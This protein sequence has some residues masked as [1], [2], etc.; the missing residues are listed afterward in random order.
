MSCITVLACSASILLYSLCTVSSLVLRGGPPLFSHLS[1]MTLS[2]RV[3]PLLVIKW[4]Y[5][6]RQTQGTLIP[7]RLGTM[8]PEQKPGG[9]DSSPRGTLETGVSSLLPGIS[10]MH[11]VSLPKVWLFR[12]SVD[13]ANNP[14]PF[15]LIR[16]F[17]DYI[18]QG[19]CLS[20]ATKEYILIH[21]IL[22]LLIYTSPGFFI[23]LCL[24]R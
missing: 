16:Y 15:L 22:V 13:S 18:S 23:F 6:P 14:M 3:P 2:S 5:D 20:M 1:W 21:T 11:W 4:A 8:T 24:D 19:S 9:A 10:E 17:I 7:W 12:L